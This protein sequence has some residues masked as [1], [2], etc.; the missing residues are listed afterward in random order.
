MLDPICNN[1]K[2]GK[3]LIQSTK[4]F[5]NNPVSNMIILCNK[6]DFWKFFYFSEFPIPAPAPS[7]FLHAF[8]RPL[9]AFPE[10][11]FQALKY[12]PAIRFPGCRF[13]AALPAE[14]FYPL[15]L[16]PSFPAILFPEQAVSFFAPLSGK[17][18]NF[19]IK[20]ALVAPLYASFGFISVLRSPGV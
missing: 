6:T 16:I 20:K 12:F 17:P 4:I 19:Y 11:L 18:P 8:P 1:R 10:S 3:K 13:A 5:L 15:L 7:P 9:H 2:P 14:T